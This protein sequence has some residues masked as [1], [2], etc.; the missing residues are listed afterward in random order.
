MSQRACL[1]WFCSYVL[2]SSRDLSRA[3]SIGVLFTSFPTFGLHLPIRCG[4]TKALALLVGLLLPVLHVLGAFF[5]FSSRFTSVEALF[6]VA[7]SQGRPPRRFDDAPYDTDRNA[8]CAR[9]SALLRMRLCRRH[10]VLTRRYS[11][12]SCGLKQLAPDAL[13]TAMAV[14]TS[15]AGPQLALVLTART[16]GEGTEAAPDGA[17]VSIFGRVV[18]CLLALARTLTKV[19]SSFCYIHRRTRPSRGC[20]WPGHLHRRLGG[21][22]VRA[23][24]W[25]RP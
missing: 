12:D 10:R 23:N 11:D 2:Q 5:G 8:S 9:A 20:Q 17:R 24:K 3:E 4:R 13:R 1:L 16:Q 21:R 14:H 15:M 18:P 25:V 19:L 22:R 6:W 7:L